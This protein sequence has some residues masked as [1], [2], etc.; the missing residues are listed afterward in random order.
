MLALR[1]QT[2]HANLLYQLWT[3]GR[4]RTQQVMGGCLIY[5]CSTHKTTPP[6]LGRV[7]ATSPCRGSTRRRRHALTSSKAQNQLKRMSTTSSMFPFLS[8]TWR[9]LWRKSL[10]QRYPHDPSPHRL[11][12]DG[13]VAARGM[14]VNGRY[15]LPGM[16]RRR[17]QILHDGDDGPRRELVSASGAPTMSHV[18]D[19]APM[20]IRSLSSS[21]AALPPAPTTVGPRPLRL[22][23]AIQR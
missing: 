3:R 20:F 22:T 4:G 15:P 1:C 5:R 10:M 8:S 17:R 12:F 19:V 9:R 11:P 18:D 6:S 16:S 21:D 13:Y 14:C 2:T 7:S 23:S